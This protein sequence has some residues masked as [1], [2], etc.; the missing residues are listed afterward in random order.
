M[1][2][3]IHLYTTIGLIFLLTGIALLPSEL[4]FIA[5]IYA[6][7]AYFC[8]IKEVATYTSNYQFITV[9]A[10]AILLGISVEHSLTLPILTIGLFFVAAGSTWK[11][12][13]KRPHHFVLN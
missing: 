3:R 10:S 5:S 2:K 13:P 12:R 7:L 11:F 6:L 8:S 9:T 1:V 4:P